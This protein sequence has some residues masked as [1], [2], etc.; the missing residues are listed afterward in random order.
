M[1]ELEIV[2]DCGPRP[3]MHE[4]GAFVEKG[5]VVLVR[6]DYEVL[7]LSKP[8][9]DREIVG[10]AADQEPGVAVA[11]LQDPGEHRRG[12]GLAVSSSY[13]EDV[14][15]GQHLLREPPPPPQGAIAA[16]EGRLP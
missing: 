6:F 8:G 10:D 9:G 1:I 13:G 4:F 11:P 14:S 16:V 15:V 7:T 5:R 3:V 12:R 2:E